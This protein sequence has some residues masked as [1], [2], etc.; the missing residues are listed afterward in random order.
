MAINK[1]ISNTM[2]INSTRKEE[3]EEAITLQLTDQSQQTSQMLSVTDVTDNGEKTNF[4]EKEEEVSLLIVCHVKE[5][6]QQNMWYLD[7]SYNNHMCGNTMMFSDLDETFCNTVKFGDN[8]TASVLGER[9]VL[10]EKEVNS[11]IKVLRSD[12]GGEYNSHEFVKFC[13][14]HGI[15]R[16]LTAAYTPQ[17]NGVCER[18]NRTI[19]NVV[20]S[21][22]TRSGV[23][24]TFW[25]EA[26][27]WSIHILNRSPTLAVQNMTPEEA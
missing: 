6:T 23:P 13:E 12:R 3:V 5:E 1:N 22:L 8:S 19:M 27:I 16:Q 2:R 25:P 4:A 21:L 20:R 24:K 9:N 10:V 18:K 15:K 11:P 7:T 17:Q 26:V 14:I